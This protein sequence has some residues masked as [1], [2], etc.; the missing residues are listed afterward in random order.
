MDVWE[1]EPEIDKELLSLVDIATPHIAG[2]S[3]DGKANG[4]AICVREISSFF[5][6]GVDKNWY[7]AEI[8]P[9]QSEKE[10]TI[11]CGGKSNQR[12]CSE[13]ILHT[14][15]VESD[16]QTLRNSVETF[17]KQRGNY[18]IRREFPFYKI[19]LVNSNNEVAKTLTEFGFNVL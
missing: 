15:K 9:P 19:K 1:N 6:L 5:N 2:Y 3:A 10:F 14:Y 8:P 16:D 7:P 13:A 4:T 17:E 18:P 12:I 11:D